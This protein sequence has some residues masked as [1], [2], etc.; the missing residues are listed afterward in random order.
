MEEKGWKEFK[1]N[2]PE[3]VGKPSRNILYRW[4]GGGRVVNGWGLD[5]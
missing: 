1:E 3:S 2:S 4:P 5:R